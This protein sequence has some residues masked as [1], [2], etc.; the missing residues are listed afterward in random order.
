MTPPTTIQIL[1]D[2][3]TLTFQEILNPTRKEP[4]YI[5]KYT[6]SITKKDQ[7][8]GLNEGELNNLIKTQK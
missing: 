4:I 2:G 3:N 8:L 6:K 7:L 1:S 5:Y